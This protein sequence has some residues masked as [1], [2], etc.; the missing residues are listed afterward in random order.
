LGK[1]DF[2]TIAA[3]PPSAYWEQRARR[4]AHAREGL[5]AV[6]SYGMP[7]FYNRY[8]QLCQQLALDRWLRVTP[9]NRV[10]DV[11]CGVGRWSLALARRGAQVTGVD[12][13]E[14]MVAEAA[15]RAA[16][17]G[18]SQRCQFV[19]QDLAE[20]AVAGSYD[21]I[22]G[23]TVL[24]HILG[25]HRLLAAMAGLSDRLAPG[26]RIVLL[27]AAPTRRAG[28]CDSPIFRARDVGEYLALFDACGLA[29]RA[30]TGVDPM[31]L[32]TMLL[33]YYRALPRPAA[34]AA[35]AA[36]TAVSLPIDAVLGRKLAR[37]SWHKVF[38]LEHAK[39]LDA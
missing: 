19:A 20:L 33:P 24:Q 39:Q 21:L 7:E 31:P 9:G 15:R 12:I 2:D 10:L 13:S 29:V 5:A 35:L 28:H 1:H 26:G 8:I 32:K 27:E 38:V 3:L 36:V 22:V 17:R 11:G 14:T 37:A 4:Y 16:A 23:V 30:I 6:C 18:L 34:L 25:E